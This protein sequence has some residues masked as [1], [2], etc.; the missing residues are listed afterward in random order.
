MK[1]AV[2]P[3][4]VFIYNP[5]LLASE[6]IHRAVQRDC[7]GDVLDYGVPRKAAGADVAVV[8]RGSNGL[9]KRA[10]VAG[11]PEVRRVQSALQSQAS[12]DDR[13]VLENPE[14]VVKERLGVTCGPLDSYPVFRA[15]RDAADVARAQEA[16]AQDDHPG[17]HPTHII[18]KRGEAVG[19]VR[20]Q[21]VP[22]VTLWLHSKQVGPRDSLGLLSALEN[23]LRLNGATMGVTVVNKASPFAAVMPKLGHVNDPN[24][25]IYMKGL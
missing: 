19:C 14:Q 1:A 8:L 13:V 24:K 20:I 9:E 3:A 17:A 15:V 2:T 11:L 7:I 16:A 25:I 18:E 21:M 23:Y 22:L 12:P 10:V 6:D 4:G 5:D